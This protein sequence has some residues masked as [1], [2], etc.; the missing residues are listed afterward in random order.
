MA[1]PFQ[2][3]RASAGC[4]AAT[5]TRRATDPRALRMN[6]IALS[7]V[8][9]TQRKTTQHHQTIPLKPKRSLGRGPRKPSVNRGDGRVNRGD[10]RYEMSSLPVIHPVS[11]QFMVF[12]YRFLRL[13]EQT[14]SGAARLRRSR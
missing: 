14:L 3:H 11:L 1:K 10:G 7:P 9:V 13:G 5:P 4:D 2:K 6:F 12:F 8:A